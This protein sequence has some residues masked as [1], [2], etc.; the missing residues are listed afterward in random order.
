MQIEICGRLIQGID[1]KW[2]LIIR[3][4][5]CLYEKNEII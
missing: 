2:L 5:S 3:F 1:I 4:I